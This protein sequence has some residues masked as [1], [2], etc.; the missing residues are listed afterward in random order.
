MDIVLGIVTL[1]IFVLIISSIYALLRDILS[2]LSDAVR[3]L[4]ARIKAVISVILALFG[5][6]FTD[7]VAKKHLP[8]LSKIEKAQERIISRQDSVMSLQDSIRQVLSRGHNAI[9][10][11]VQIL[12][13]DQQ[14]ALLKID[15]LNACIDSHF[16]NVRARLIRMEKKLE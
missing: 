8:D 2:Q 11:N 4:R 6:W 10:E 7:S 14:K 9:V 15:S 3:N 12:Q 5:I 1:L 13:H 16:V